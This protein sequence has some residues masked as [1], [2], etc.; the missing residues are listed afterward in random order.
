M[1][2]AFNS[3]STQRVFYGSVMNQAE[4]QTNA[5]NTSK[6]QLAN[7]ENSLAGADLAATATRLSSDETSLNA[8]MSAMAHYQQMNLFDYLR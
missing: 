8:T 1:T 5:L 2:S 3:I 6:V 7:E 4:S